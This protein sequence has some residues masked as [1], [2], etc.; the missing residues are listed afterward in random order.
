MNA[1]AIIALVATVIKTAVDL[2]PTIIKTVEDA[3]PFAKI[4]WGNL[5]NNQ[6][7]TPDDLATL[8]AQLT[9]L[10]A[11]LQAPLPPEQPDDV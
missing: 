6:V 9:A 10:S 8:E 2:T 1:E 3:E 7:I 11:Q 4:I 5:I